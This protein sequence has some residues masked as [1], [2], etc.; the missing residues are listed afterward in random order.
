MSGNASDFPLTH[1]VLV[2]PLATSNQPSPPAARS[3]DV[4]L[5]FE[6]LRR[7]AQRHRT[8]PS[9]RESVNLTD[10][11]GEGTLNTEGLWRRGA[12]SWH[13]GAGQLYVD[14]K[15][16]DEWRFY[17]SQG[18]D[19]WTENQLSL[20][21]DTKQQISSVYTWAQIVTPGSYVY[22]LESNDPEPANFSRVRFTQDYVTWYTPTGLTGHV[23]WLATD[24]ANVYAAGAGGVW[25]TGAGT[26]TWTQIIT[27]AVYQIWYVADRLIVSGPNATLYDLTSINSVNNSSAQALD[28]QGFFDQHINPNWTWSSAAAGNSCLYIGG[29]LTVPTPVDSYTLNEPVITAPSAVYKYTI[30]N[31]NSTQQALQAVPSINLAPG[32]IALPME[33]GEIVSGLFSYL[34]YIFVGTSLGVRCCRTVSANDPS[35]D[36]GDLIAGQLM[37]NLLQ[38]LQQGG[39]F[40]ENKFIATSNFTAFGRYVWFDF[41]G[42]GNDQYALM[43][44]DLGTFT[45]ELTPA[46]ALDLVYN[47]A[48]GTGAVGVPGC[49]RWCPIT[50][51]PVIALTQAGV[52]TQDTQHYVASGTLKSGRI[53][54]G[55]PD[56][57]LAAQ[58]NY[59]TRPNDGA[60]PYEAGA[61]T[62]TMS[63]AADGSAYAAMSPLAPNVQAN[64]PVLLSPLTQGEEFEVELTLT[65]ANNRTQRPFLSRWTLKALPQVVSGV[66]LTLVIRSWRYNEVHGVMIT[67]NE[68]YDDYAFFE[69]LRLAQTPVTYQE[70]SA[71]GLSV[72]YEAV[73]VV[74]AI[75]WLPFRERE[76]VE[77]GFEGVIVISFKT[78]VG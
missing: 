34:N 74:E 18:I 23:S 27:T 71:D 72:Q 7:D 52:W 33:N 47:T 48:P 32:T 59:N 73:A 58:A 69:N 36:A 37:P 44:C 51:G 24:G 77:G 54:Y 60:A 78:I 13:H 64:P 76:D 29:Y 53:T 28:P 49:M 12:T 55:L 3:F 35:G 8:I 63:L 11:A 4:D 15:D 57:K 68:P 31:T 65:A 5:S 38:P 70:G 9:Q 67:P 22:Y 46:Y 62:V 14:R 61:G 16:S 39:V 43:R 2:T 40:N 6:A 42:Y 45:S 75:D 10:I 50:N 1:P 17:E 41:P 26:G 19:C 66:E 56:Q 30:S 20:L 25:Y 21:P